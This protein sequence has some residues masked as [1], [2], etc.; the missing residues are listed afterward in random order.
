MTTHTLKVKVTVNDVE[1]DGPSH[2]SFSMEGEIAE[3]ILSFP[4]GSRSR[5]R[6]TKKD[7]VK[8]FI[9]LDE[10]RVENPEGFIDFTNLRLNQPSE[11]SA[12]SLG[13]YLM[14]NLY[15]EYKTQLR[16]PGVTGTGEAPTP[17]LGWEA[18]NRIY[19]EYRINRNWSVSSFYV[20]QIYDKFKIDI[21]W[22]Y[23][24]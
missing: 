5:Y 9:G 24:F 18:G 11:Q 15:L 7:L 3:A 14:P 22:R 19:L 2:F 16:S 8:V 6:I 21:S 12:I 20:K 17:R 1:F 10:I 13:K 23:S 4:G